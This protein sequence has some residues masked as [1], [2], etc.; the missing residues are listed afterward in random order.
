MSLIGNIEDFPDNDTRSIE[1]G[2]LPL[3]VVKRGGELFIYENNCPHTRETLDPMGGP[4]ISP[5]GLLLHCQRH[6]AEFI[7]E[8]GECV[9]GPCLGERLNPVAFTLSNGDI[10]LD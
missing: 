7:T 1:V 10:Y 9:S 5:D 2:P 3:L 6:S 8:T 4:V